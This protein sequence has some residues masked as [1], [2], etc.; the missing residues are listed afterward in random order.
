MV[1]LGYGLTRAKVFSKEQ[2]GGIS[3]FAFY[4]S[5]PAFLF[6]NMLKANLSLSLNVG[7]MVTF[8]LPVVAVFFIGVFINDALVKLWGKKAGAFV[9]SSRAGASRA[10]YGLGCSYSNTVLVGLPIIVAALGEQMMGL[11]FVIITFHSA[12]LFALTFLLGQ[13]GAANTD[14]TFYETAN[15]ESANARRKLVSF[16]LKSFLRSIVLNPVVLSISLGI[17]VNASGL[18]LSSELVAGLS[19]LSEPALASALFVLGANL[20]F[21]RVREGW[22]LAAMASWIKLMLLPALVYLLGHFVF[23]LQPQTLAV[24]VLLSA[25]PLG[26]NSYLIAT[27]LKAHQGTLGSTVVLSTLL[28]VPSFA[29][30]LWWLL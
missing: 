24:I 6:L 25:S 12:L 5:I 29:F 28:S 20:S 2:I 22:Q 18:S 13:M 3:Q 8:Y 10:V 1:C 4:I 19:L 14:E 17:I 21:Y 23:A 26:V 9:D 7:A 11:V 16:D 27:Q 15:R 30:W